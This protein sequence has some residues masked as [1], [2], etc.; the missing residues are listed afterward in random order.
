[1]GEAL[2]DSLIRQGT[3][4][5]TRPQSVF[6]KLRQGLLGGVTFDRPSPAAEA[7][8]LFGDV[9]RNVIALG[10]GVAADRVGGPN[11]DI[12]PTELFGGSAAISVRRGRAT[13]FVWVGPRGNLVLLGQPTDAVSSRFCVTLSGADGC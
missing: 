6:S 7:R 12:A 10:I 3:F 2:R 1:M 9:D 5:G 11:A 13:P 4:D 8:L